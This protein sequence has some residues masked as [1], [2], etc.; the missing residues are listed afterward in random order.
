MTQKHARTPC[1]LGFYKTICQPNGETCGGI[2]ITSHLGRPIEFQCSL[3]IRPNRTQQTLY[4]TTLFSF[5]KGELIAEALRDKLSVKPD[6]LFVDDME[7]V[8]ESTWGEIPVICF[9]ADTS[10]E[11]QM[12]LRNHTVF[13]PQKHQAALQEKLNL[14]DQHVPET[15]DLREPL[16][17]VEQ[18]LQEACGHAA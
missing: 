1:V 8:S 12:K 18:A 13:V 11:E 14:L 6:I 10:T 2:L 16:F 4:G 15:A 7:A 3:P 5:L 17:R 9:Q